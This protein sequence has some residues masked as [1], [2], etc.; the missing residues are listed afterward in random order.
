M[1]LGDFTSSMDLL[2]ST[3]HYDLSTSELGLCYNSVWR[4]LSRLQIHKSPRPDDLRPRF[5]NEG[6]FILPIFERS[7]LSG[8][9]TVIWKRANITAIK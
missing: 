4:C 1:Y 8:R 7:V 5:L 2:V 9:L 6:S 3:G